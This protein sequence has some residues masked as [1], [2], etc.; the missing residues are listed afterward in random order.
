MLSLGGLDLVG[1]D[2]QRYLSARSVSYS[3]EE[4]LKAERVSWSR[5]S[6]GLPPVCGSIAMLDLCEGHIREALLSPM[7]FIQAEAQAPA[8]A[9]LHIQAGQRLEIA[10]GLLQRGI[11]IP[12]PLGQEVHIQGVPVLNGMFGV[13]KSGDK[14]WADGQWLAPLRLIMNLVPLNSICRELR[15]DVDLLPSIIQLRTIKSSFGFLSPNLYKC[16][17]RI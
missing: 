14:I 17:L 13:E 5:I 3:G 15:A 11:C 16:L 7:T 10:R 9:K 6:P 1:M 2:W 12:V 8:S 4:V